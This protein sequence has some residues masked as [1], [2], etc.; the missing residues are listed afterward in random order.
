MLPMRTVEKNRHSDRP[1]TIP[2]IPLVQYLLTHSKA[3]LKKAG[4]KVVAQFGQKMV[5]FKPDPNATW[6]YQPEMAQDITKSEVLAENS[7]SGVDSDEDVV[8]ADVRWGHVLFDTQTP[9]LSEHWLHRT[10]TSLG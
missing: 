7:D 1:P 2:C 10:G 5:M 6:T 8:P 4:H 9:I 3:E